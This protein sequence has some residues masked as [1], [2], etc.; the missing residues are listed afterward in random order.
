[1]T[2]LWQQAATER[3]VLTL[4]QAD[5][6]RRH[7]MP[8][9]LAAE[10]GDTRSWHCFERIEGDWALV[11]VKLSEGRAGVP[12]L[13]APFPFPPPD[14]GAVLRSSIPEN[15]AQLIGYVEAMNLIARFGLAVGFRY[16]K[17]GAPAE[18]R[19]GLALGLNSKQLFVSDHDREGETRGF[20]LS[21]MDSLH[22]LDGQRVPVWREGVG[23]TVLPG[24][25]EASAQP[26]PTVN[27]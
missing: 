14:V 22:L 10:G 5:G 15:P 4:T 18:T 20:L 21:R 23:Y 11:T 8:L 1:M 17:P 6:T 12:Q 25:D 16:T 24:G 9:R 13:G 7:V 2:D 3:R 26:L 27:P 19:K